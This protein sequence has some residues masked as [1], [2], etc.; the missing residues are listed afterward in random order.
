MMMMVMM[1][2]RTRRRRRRVMM[3]MTIT[4]NGAHLLPG[5]LDHGEGAVGGLGH[6]L[7]DLT[8]LLVLLRDEVHRLLTRA[9]QDTVSAPSSSSSSL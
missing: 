7:L 9:S 2:R 6:A 4:I 8:D 5:L 1:R 3:M